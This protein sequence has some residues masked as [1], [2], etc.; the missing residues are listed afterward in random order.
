[1]GY[2]K[3]IHNPDGFKRRKLP[4]TKEYLNRI[5]KEYSLIIFRLWIDWILLS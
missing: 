1:M 4:H 3:T 2:T 5:K